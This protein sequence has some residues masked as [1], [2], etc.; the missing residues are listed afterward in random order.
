MK[1]IIATMVN[2]SQN[3]TLAI[4]GAFELRVICVNKMGESVAL[5]TDKEVSK[6][7]F[8]LTY[9]LAHDKFLYTSRTLPSSTVEGLIADI[10][11]AMEDIMNEISHRLIKN[12]KNGYILGKPREVF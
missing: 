9:T 3:M 6:R 11:I 2:A 12:F 7:I 8:E 1:K 5:S 10:P 4:N